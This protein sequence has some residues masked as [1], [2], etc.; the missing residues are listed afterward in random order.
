[1]ATFRTTKSRSNSTAE[2]NATDLKN[3]VRESRLIQ[4]DQWDLPGIQEKFERVIY[5]VSE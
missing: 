4:Q 1:M 2:E 5:H 3:T